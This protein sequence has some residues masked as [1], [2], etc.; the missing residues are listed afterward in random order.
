MPAPDPT[1]LD[2]PPA[3]TRHTAR[4]R[5]VAILGGVLALFLLL[6]A[7]IIWRGGRTQRVIAEIEARGG[8]VH[9]YNTD[10]P[11]FVRIAARLAGFDE[12][13]TY[14]VFLDGPEFDDAW[15]TDNEY[16]AALPVRQLLLRNTRVRREAIRELLRVHQLHTFTA[17]GSVVQDDDMLLL[18][19]HR[20][21]THL[22]VEY[23]AV[24]DSG[25]MV[26][27][28]ER[29]L[30]PMLGGSK[31]TPAGLSVFQGSTKLQ[32][33][34][35]DGRQLTPEIAQM[36]LTCPKVHFVR[37]VGPEVDDACLQ[38]LNGLKSLT[39]VVLDGTSVTDEGIAQFNATSPSCGV[40]VVPPEERFYPPP[41][42]SFR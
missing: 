42:Q 12:G 7:Y 41:V 35:L 9:A 38:N 17:P 29:L 16:L 32:G 6:T 2:E 3:R 11:A 14:D 27:G 20:D 13:P 37:L 40:H 26:I 10:G 22:S 24:G 36:L 19:N 31:V 5:L 28:P 30:Y 1:A 4:Y 33:I 25:L 8:Q 23:T 15:L 39:G 21:L 34:G 18:G